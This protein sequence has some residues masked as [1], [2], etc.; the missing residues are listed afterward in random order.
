MTL[1]GPDR[2]DERGPVVA[3]LR[4]FG[5]QIAAVIGIAALITAI[6]ALLSSDDGGKVNAVPGAASGS[7]T[8]APATSAPATSAPATTAP[9]STATTTAPAPPSPATTSPASTATPDSG[10]KVDVLNQS[11]GGGAAEQ[12][13][14]RLQ[15][16][17]WQIGRV[18]NFSGNVRTT[19]VYWLDPADRKAARRLARDLGGVRVLQGFGTLR[20]GRLSVVLVEKP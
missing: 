16:A 4:L 19:T 15:A 1:P 17:G 3:V 6:V 14:Q 18:D 11:A 12:V 10:P 9:P 13:A 2:D 5:L 7:A 20:T 8:R